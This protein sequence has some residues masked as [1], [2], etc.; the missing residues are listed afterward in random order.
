MSFD[1]SDDYDEGEYGKL[2]SESVSAGMY[3]TGL[4][5]LLRGL[6][7]PLGVTL[8]SDQSCDGDGGSLVFPYKNV[9][10]VC[11]I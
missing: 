10:D 5:G 3:G 9:G 11:T 2:G 6:G 7:F 4:G 1:E 8:F